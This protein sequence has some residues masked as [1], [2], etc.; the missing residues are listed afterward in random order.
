MYNLELIKMN[1]DDM[2]KVRFWRMLPQVTKYMYSDPKI[3]LVGQLEWFK[4]IAQD[5]TSKYWV[6]TFNNIKI[7][8][9]NFYDIDIKNK[10]CNWAY[11]IG[12]MSFRGKRIGYN[13][14]CNIYDF[15]FYT[16]NFNKLSCE[17]FK[18]NEK[19][20]KLHDRIGAKI[21]GEFKEHI[22]KNDEYFTIIKMSML[23]N[24]WDTIRKQHDYK[25]IKIEVI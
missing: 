14:E 4:K 8:V 11:Y 5:K 1:K 22:K 21:E 13:L 12:D 17:I 6:I 3:T 20:I 25:K 9:L 7:G 10:K 16:L 15:V 23:K 19:V 18:W 2:E 24:E